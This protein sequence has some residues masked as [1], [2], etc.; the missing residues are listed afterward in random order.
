MSEKEICI[1][2][3]NIYTDFK[4]RKMIKR[5]NLYFN[6]RYLWYCPKTVFAPQLGNYTISFSKRNIRICC[7]KKD[8]NTEQYQRS[9]NILKSFIEDNLQ[10]NIIGITFNP[11]C[12][13]LDLVSNIKKIN[14]Q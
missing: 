14:I 3:L 1:N 7:W 13:I 10:N 11:D 9:K 2:E 8:E 6:N 12:D 5:A 4:Y